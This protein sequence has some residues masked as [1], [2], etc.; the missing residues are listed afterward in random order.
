MTGKHYDETDLEDL[1]ETANMI[2][3][4]IE[5]RMLGNAFNFPSQSTRW[6]ES[7]PMGIDAPA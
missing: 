4:E 5:R 6:F 1:R 7:P 2:G 3:D